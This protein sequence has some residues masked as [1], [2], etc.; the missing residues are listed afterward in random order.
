MN[1]EFELK[2][3]W[4]FPDNPE[5]TFFGTLIFNP[6]KGAFLEL[7]D[8]HKKLK[9][10]VPTEK[11]IILGISSDGNKITLHGC[12]C[13]NNNKYF[14]TYHFSS[15]IIFIGAHFHKTEDIK[16]KN[17]TVHYSYLDEWFN[18]SGFH[19]DDSK[20]K[21]P[22]MNEIIIKYKTLESVNIFLNNNYKLTLYVTEYTDNERT[23]VNI[24]RKTFINIEFNQEESIANIFIILRGIRNFLSFA[25]SEKVYLISIEGVLEENNG[26][27]EENFYNEKVKIYYKIAGI[28]KVTE[29]VNPNNIL[30]KFHDISDRFEIILNKWLN[31]ASSLEIFFNL[32]FEIIYNSGIH[33]EHKFLNLILALEAY[34]R[35]TKENFELPEDKFKDMLDEIV[36]FVPEKYKSWLREKLN[37]SNEKNLRRRLKEIMDEFSYAISLFI[38]DENIKHFI[39]K[40]IK[41]RN[42]LIHKD[43]KIEKNVAKDK[44][45]FYLVEKLKLIVE[46]CILKELGF[47]QDEIKDKVHK[48]SNRLKNIHYFSSSQIIRNI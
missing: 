21:D 44:E 41:T 12:Y 20:I 16:F 17:I 13:Y 14:T 15:Y 45:L 37:Y 2:G 7:L 46:I 4:W 48:I 1:E 23:Q 18:I 5:E 8:F 40:V 29:K 19:I 28:S 9:I 34:H 35:K 22:N 39:D 42:Y 3:I 47:T 31:K 38:Q 36:N 32:Y 6:Y 25:L 26:I 11:E 33:L 30:F 43:D 10:D 27:T 24:K